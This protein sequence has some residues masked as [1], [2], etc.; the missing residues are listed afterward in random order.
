MG[1]FMFGILIGYVVGV[2]VMFFLGSIHDK[3]GE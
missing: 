2:L 3:N 1:N